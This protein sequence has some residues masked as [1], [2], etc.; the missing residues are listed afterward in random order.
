MISLMRR[1]FGLAA[2][3]A[4][5]GGASASAQPGAPTVRLP[6]GSLVPALG[7]GSAGPP[8]GPQPR[9]HQEGGPPPGHPPPQKPPETPASFPDRN[10]RQRA[11]G[12]IPGA[13]D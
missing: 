12:A 13:R 3:A 5:V 1:Q 4:S 6:D 9:P 11:G 8:G 2:M 7:Q 10:A